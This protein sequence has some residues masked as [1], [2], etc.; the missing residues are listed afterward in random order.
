MTR[1][2]ATGPAQ[3]AWVDDV[4]AVLTRRDPTAAPDRQAGRFYGD[5]TSCGS[6]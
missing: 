6:T 5:G 3:A 2:A 4:D 1:T